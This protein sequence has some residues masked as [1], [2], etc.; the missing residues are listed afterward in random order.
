MMKSDISFCSNSLV[1]SND[2]DGDQHSNTS[3]FYNKI[4]KSSESA[5]SQQQQHGSVANYQQLPSSLFVASNNKE[6]V[7]IIHRREKRGKNTIPNREAFKSLGTDG[8]KIDWIVNTVRNAGELST[9]INSDRIFLMRITKI[10]EC[11]RDHFDYN[12][13]AFLA[14]NPRVKYT[15]FKCNCYV[16]G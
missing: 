4:K 9:Y 15:T 6:R 1:M 8:E 3:L 16:E 5:M 13:D 11:L 10:F 14:Q 7:N 2:D 12:S